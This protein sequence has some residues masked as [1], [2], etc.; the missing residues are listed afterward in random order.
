MKD[1]IEV[2]KK[3]REKLSQDDI[4]KIHVGNM[5]EGDRYTLNGHKK[6]LKAYVNMEYYKIIGNKDCIRDYFITDLKANKNQLSILILFF[7]S[8]LMI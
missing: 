6:V 5:G 8:L 7:L 1:Y 3:E 2:Y 4:E